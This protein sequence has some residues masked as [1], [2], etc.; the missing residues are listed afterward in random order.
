MVGSL[1]ALD[2]KLLRDLLRLR[3]Q[4]LAIA[5]VI[6]SGVA[7]LV[8]SLAA[9]QSLQ[10]SVD[11]YYDRH[12][13]AD[14][15]ATVKRA[16]DSLDEHLARIAGVQ[17]VETRIVELASL[18]ITG[19]DEPV[20]ATLVSV[21]KKQAGALNRLALRTGR[22]PAINRYHEAVVN[23]AFAE[24]HGLQ[25]GDSFRA[26]INGHRQPLTIVGVALSPEFIYAIGPGAL[27][28]DAKHYGIV[29]MSGEALA[30]AYDLESAFNSVLMTLR[31]DAIISSVLHQVDELLDRYGGVGAIARKD[32]ISNWFV[33]NEIA[34]LYS[35]A[36]IL[37]TI[38]LAVAAFLA[39]M[40]LARLIATERSEIGLL[41]AFGYSSFD[42]A[43]H[44][45]R[46]IVFIS[47][48]GIVLG[49]LVGY[50]WGEWMTRLYTDFYRFPALLYTPGSQAFVISA[51]V[52]LAAT[53]SGGVL[54]ARRAAQLPPAE[55]MR[56]PAPPSFGHGRRKLN[57][58]NALLDQSTRIFVRQML[59]WP[60]R[61][62]L[63]SM[64]IGASIALL[65]TSLQWNDSIAAM[66]DDYFYAQQ[67]Q[68]AIIS[69]AD[70]RPVAVATEFQ[71][72][73][74]VLAA[75]AGRY[76]SARLH[77]RHL[78]KREA[79]IGLP[80]DAQLSIIRDHNG[81]TIDMPAAGLLLSTKLAELLDVSI[82]DS[83]RVEVLQGRRPDVSVPVVALFDTLIGAPAYMNNEALN[84]LLKEDNNANVVYLLVDE[85]AER[86][87][88]K[89]LIDIPA[90]GAVMMRKAAINMFNESIA[91]VM[92]IY[93]AFYTVFTCAL[94]I[95]VTYNA[96]RI[97]LSERG[98]ELAT[99]RVLGFT[100]GE[101]SY[102]LLGEMAALVALSLPLGCLM[103]YALSVIMVAAFETELFRIPYVMVPSTYAK[104]VLVVLASTLL[105]AFL[106]HRRLVRLDLIKVLKTRE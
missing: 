69:L 26:L 63:T 10:S 24:A 89:A 100:N 94:A 20:A 56:P 74:G 92:L 65:V 47:V 44:Y 40:V 2:R 34:Q 75:E 60:V 83:V 67:R 41:K 78:S 55:A 79:I 73:N 68:D 8:M 76:V 12:R 72:M 29:W 53:L 59:R 7:V 58:F 36:K 77:N 54:A 37:P 45:A 96:M 6:A 95:G 11:A 32:Q 23:E 51:L 66:I 103:G 33:Q 4:V 48:I 84:V 22:L 16:P 42:V 91:E 9:A 21:S 31:H 70:T 52:S 15:F 106:I 64:G 99:L 101:I 62:L 50:W 27:M 98:R 25:P 43:W 18:S 5:L 104:A 1:R 85:N 3:G 97:A 49:W 88:L 105:S 93:I 46:L 80:S 35:M 19:F 13:F 102:V 14:V 86:G 71:R 90:V 82:G 81:Q 39:N 28:P 57:R 30:A 38:F 17:Q 87:L 61:S